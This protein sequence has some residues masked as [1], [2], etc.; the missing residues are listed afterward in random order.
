[1][2]TPAFIVSIL[3]LIP[4][5]DVAK[6]DPGPSQA[7]QALSGNQTY[8]PLAADA[9]LAVPP[10]A[11]LFFGGDW[12]E[13]TYQTLY[14]GGQV[15][16]SV[17]PSRFPSCGTQGVVTLFLRGEDGRVSETRLDGGSPGE[18]RWGAAPLPSSGRSVEAWLRSDRGDGCVEWDSNLDQNYRFDLHAWRPVRVR[19]TGDWQEIAEA[20]L[21]RGG[22]LV[23]DYDW[24]R[25]P[26]CRVIFRGFPGWDII[27]HVRF[28]DGTYYGQSTVGRLG[29]SE[30]ERRL[31]VIPIPEHAQRVSIWFENDQY[32]PTCHAWDSNYGANYEFGLD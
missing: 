22:V 8:G 18:S 11:S 7:D 28:D 15:S 19:F 20:P 4:G 21:A 10:G 16:V 1:M 5:C 9:D 6:V 24:N 14:T 17:D 31:A 29:P 23:I 13:S 12:N 30:L 25:L 26:D 3:L 27:A 2:R 32:P